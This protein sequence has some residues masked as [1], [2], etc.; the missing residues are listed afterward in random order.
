MN[1]DS[2]KIE[3]SFGV[4]TSL[5]GALQKSIEFCKEYKTEV[6]KSG[7]IKIRGDVVPIIDLK[8]YFNEKD[9]HQ[10]RQNIIIAK[11]ANSLVGLIVD[12]FYE[13]Q[14][15]V[16][17]PLGALFDKG[18]GISG[19]TIL[20]NGEVAMIIDIP[21]LIEYQILNFTRGEK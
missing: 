13:E 19:G 8:K 4:G 2:K 20:G 12:D 10:L 18:P 1:I 17:K 5:N 21:K 16:I 15:I 3:V 11:Y 7:F 6:S 14:Q 9:T